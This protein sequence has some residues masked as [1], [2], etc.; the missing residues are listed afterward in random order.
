MSMSFC[1]N[2]ITMMREDYRIAT[3][4]DVLC[5]VE[6]H[7]GE[8]RTANEERRTSMITKSKEPLDH[9]VTWQYWLS[10]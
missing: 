10:S 7:N 1:V 2:G 5:A 4:L 6:R 9:H 8:R 3:V